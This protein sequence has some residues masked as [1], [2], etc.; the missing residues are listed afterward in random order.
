MLWI[1]DAW[2]T[3]RETGLLPWRRTLQQFEDQGLAKVTTCSR[4][5]EFA[6]HLRTPENVTNPSFDLLVI[7]VMLTDEP[8][9]TYSCLGFPEEQVMRLDAGVQIAVLI[10]SST[11]D[12]GRPHWLSPYQSVPILLLSAT[13]SLRSLVDGKLGYRRREK[14]LM[15]PKDLVRRTDQS[16]YDAHPDFG[17][18]VKSLL[19]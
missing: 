1:D 18:A 7:D 17:V 12:L 3:E 5:A 10:R 8:E 14:L 13:P 6:R 15:L 16:G 4:L 19:D 9:S 2:G 11:F